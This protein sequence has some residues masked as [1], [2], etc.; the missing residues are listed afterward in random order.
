MPQITLPTR[1]AQKSATLMDNILIN[2]H[3]YKCISGNM[4][5]FIS[6]HLPQFLIFKNFKENNI[7]KNENRILFKDFKNFNM[8][9]F[10]RDLSAI[11]WYLTTENMI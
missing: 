1:V 7:T 8:D 3:E 5:S 10:E 6:D 11:G 4:T 9:T 2:H